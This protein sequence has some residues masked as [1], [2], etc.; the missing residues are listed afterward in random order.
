M[1]KKRLLILAR[2][3]LV[4]PE[5]AHEKSDAEM[6]PWKTEFDVKMTA[7]SL[8][9]DTEVLGVL[10]DLAPLREKLL[11]WKPHLVFN[12]LEE[13]HYSP[14]YESHIVSY[15]ELLKQPYT[16][17]NPRGLLIARDKVLT[18]RLLL[19]H[20]IPTPR[21]IVAPRNRKFKLPSSLQFPLLVKSATEDA[22]R[23]I[24]QRS[25]VYSE[26]KL[27]ERIEYM[28]HQIE[29][30]ALVEEYIDG[31]ELYVS[32]IGNTRLTLFPTWEL[33][34]SGLPSGSERIATERLKFDENYQKKYNINSHPAS[35]LLP[36][37]SERIQKVA[38][39]VFKVLFL[40]GYARIDLRLTEEGKVY[41]LEAN[42][43]PQLSFGEDFAE[44][45]LAFGLSY[46]QLIEK[47]MRLG[48]GYL[49]S[50]E[51]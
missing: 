25:V 17:C 26:S 38:R 33:D 6:A 40:S 37:V 10:D 7:S 32:I 20:R 11:G 47:I 44:S 27:L 23:G 16:G 9:H 51:G 43:N 28:H 48:L 8:G 5:D 13:F 30:D 15:L 45:G 46:E 4:P 21:F 24:S 18:K 31:R 2:E 50:W 49:P 1:R 42:P 3:G 41:V 34:F 12:L 22:S 14:F 39:R 29:S 35:D 19:F 36:E